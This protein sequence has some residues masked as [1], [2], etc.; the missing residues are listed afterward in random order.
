MCFDVS[1][2]LAL[3][4]LK[5]Q[6]EEVCSLW[7]IYLP[8]ASWRCSWQTN[9]L[10]L[11]NTCLPW[12]CDQAALLMQWAP[13]T[14]SALCVTVASGPYPGLFNRVTF[15]WPLPLGAKSSQAAALAV[16]LRNSASSKCLS[17]L[18][19]LTTSKLWKLLLLRDPGCL[20]PA[21][22]LQALGNDC[23][24]YSV[25]YFCSQFL[26]PRWR[27]LNGFLRRVCRLFMSHAGNQ[28]FRRKVPHLTHG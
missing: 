27:V 23:M 6:A 13:K 12:C 10:P 22:G 7:F 19:P 17:R 11:G 15:R 4:L 8:T 21:F 28:P 25:R 2:Y 18:C 1:A 3:L 9:L 20:P 5:I 26:S 24:F 16:L 14:A